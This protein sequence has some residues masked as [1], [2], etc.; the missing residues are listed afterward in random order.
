VVH[1]LWYG[2][3]LHPLGPSGLV[4]S[5]ST[6]SG[7][8]ATSNASSCWAFT[9]SRKEVSTETSSTALTSKWRCTASDACS[10]T[11]G[12]VGAQGVQCGVWWWWCLELVLHLG[13][14]EVVLVVSNGSGVPVLEF[15]TLQRREV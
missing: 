11:H 3:T 5:R 2:A 8:F 15:H 10:Y 9:L 13:E 6:R 12:R 14:L 4:A 1:A 7:A